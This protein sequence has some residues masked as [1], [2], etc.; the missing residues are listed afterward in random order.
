[1]E[2][3]TTKARKEDHKCAVCKKLI[4]IGVEHIAFIEKGGDWKSFG[5]KI[6]YCSKAC[7]NIQLTQ[8]SEI[9][10]KLVI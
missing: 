4:P 2:I 1:M 3:T 10:D 9:V 8:Y 6:R 7:A 5:K